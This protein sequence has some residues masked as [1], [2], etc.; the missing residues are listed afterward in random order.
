VRRLEALGAAGIEGSRGMAEATIDIVPGH[1]TRD[2]GE[3]HD[4]VVD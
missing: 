4:S 1:A 2:L 3:V